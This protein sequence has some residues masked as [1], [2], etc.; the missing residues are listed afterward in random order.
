MQRCL[1]PFGLLR[2]R[3]PRSANE[4][5]AQAVAEALAAEKQKQDEL[6]AELAAVKAE[7]ARAAHGV[8]DGCAYPTAFH[9][10]RYTLPLCRSHTLP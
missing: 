1:R 6:A 7:L 10:D 2:A 9:K 3:Q 4:Q 5:Q 8:T